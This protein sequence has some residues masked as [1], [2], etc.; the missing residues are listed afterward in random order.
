[1]LIYYLGRGDNRTNIQPFPAGFRMLSGDSG[2]RS[3]DNTTF[4]FGGTGG[5][6]YVNGTNTSNGTL[7]GGTFVDGK[8]TGIRFTGRPISDR[9]S[10]ACLDA[11]PAPETPNM[12]STSCSYGLRAQIQFQSC[13]DGVNLYKSDNSHVA[14][15]SQ[16]DNGVCPPTHPVQLLHLFFETL[17]SVNSISQDGGQ[18]VFSQG[19]TTGYGYHGD[20]LSGWD[21]NVQ[22]AAIR[23]C[24]LPDNGG[25][26]SACPP[27]AA[28][29]MS[30]ASFNCPERPPLV[31]EPVHNR[32]AKLPGCINLTSGPGRALSSDMNCAANAPTPAINTPTNTGP[33]STF[34]PQA[35]TTYDG[36][37]YLGC[38]NETDG[39]RTLPGA[40]TVSD[41]MSNALCQSFCA[42]KGFPLAGTEYSRECY[43]GF[44]LDPTTSLGQNCNARVCAGNNSEYCGGPNRVS[45]WNSTTYT[46][47]LQPFPS[48]VGDTMGSSV[49]LGCTVDDTGNRALGQASY[50]NRTGLTNDAC[51]S[52]C[53]SKNLPLWGTEYASECYC[54][55]ALKSY[56]VLGSS[57]CSMACAGNS[58]QICGG[59]SR[60]TIFNNTAVT[61]V[62][63]PV[64]VP[65]GTKIGS[66]VYLGCASEAYPGRALS[67]ASYVDKSGMTN[68]ACS[69]FCAAKR[70]AL[71]GTEYSAECYCGNA[72]TTGA[73]YPVLGC[74]NTCT[75]N[76]SSTSPFAPYTNIC[77][78]G[79]RL[80][81]WNNTA[82]VAA[83]AP[84]T[85]TAGAT[86]GT[87][88]YLG[89][90]AEPNSGG[91]ALASASLVDT[92]GMTN[93]L[94]A[95]YCATKGFM[96]F[97]TEYTSE[98]YC[99]N[100]LSTGTIYPQ[101]GCGMACSGSLSSSSPFAKFENTCGG[102]N[103]LSLWNNTAVKTTGAVQS[104]GNYVHQGCYTDNVG[105][106]TLSSASYSDSNNMTVEACVAFCSSKS[107]KFA[108]VEYAQE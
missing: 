98:C 2:A 73:S 45:V 101:A 9:V 92:S 69:S 52:F 67:S 4:T 38:A 96:L 1:M 51:M 21:M 59:P 37:T 107:F 90:A 13:W 7:T 61:P 89:C 12:A 83:A 77:G 104:V 20:F 95:S 64:D 87:N 88:V 3:Y 97:A 19:D 82:I 76:V 35:G 106:R 33:I 68:E 27:L 43:C 31:D 29:D 42:S 47:P 30:E 85:P 41:S 103:R 86:A 26:I 28:S 24:A 100:T 94:C 18:F 81:L 71:F 17:Y 40:S 14:Y 84:V 53:A 91:R 102:P 78:G 25:A 70:Y 15:M 57:T 36:W 65:I 66:L 8:T 6:T 50:T 56:A 60:M 80:S 54:D 11:V 55:V 46:G 32:I 10:F 34:L 23:Q 72:L 63:V 58:S 79:N 99:G 75:G 105:G 62:K 108:G 49:Y 93:E 5:V 22:A 74:G 39:G 16:I 44:K 48:K